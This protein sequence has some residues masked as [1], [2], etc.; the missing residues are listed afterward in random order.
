MRRQRYFIFK[1]R[2]GEIKCHDQK[3][4]EPG[5]V[6]AAITL[7]A[8][9]SSVFWQPAHRSR[10]RRENSRSI[11]RLASALEV[12]RAGSTPGPVLHTLASQVGDTANTFHRLT[13]HRYSRYRTESYF[14]AK[15]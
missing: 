6:R 1:D 5:D 4:R 13:P 11:I 15:V 8:C 14:K 9:G 2:D 3:A 7:S 12:P 10:E